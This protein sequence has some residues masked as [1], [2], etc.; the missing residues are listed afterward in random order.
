VAAA[1]PTPTIAAQATQPI[2]PH[3]GEQLPFLLRLVREIR[4]Q[5]KAIENMAILYLALLR[6][7]AEVQGLRSE[8]CQEQ[9]KRKAHELESATSS[10]NTSD[11]CES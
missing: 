3:P 2:L 10:D 8:L 5:R 9:R 11:A 1:G 4:E 7:A 6:V